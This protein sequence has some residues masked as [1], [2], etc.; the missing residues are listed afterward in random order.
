MRNVCD[1]GCRY[2]LSGHGSAYLGR[3]D[4]LC[5]ADCSLM[6]PK[7]HSHIARFGY[8]KR[9]NPGHIHSTSAGA[10]PGEVH[11]LVYSFLR[12]AH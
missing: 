9:P 12:C 5:P 4:R 7:H 1:C 10:K 6:W 8:C 11:G 3:D 2:A